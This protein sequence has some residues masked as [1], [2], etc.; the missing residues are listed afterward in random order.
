MQIGNSKYR[1]GRK[2][3]KERTPLIVKFVCDFLLLASL[4]IAVIWPDDVIA[5]KIGV[6][7]KLAS[8]F[9]SEH[10]P[11]AVQQD[12]ADNKDNANEQ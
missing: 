3:W 12:I 11:H 8:N 5:L 1:V 6:A 4:L 10:M 7:I 2:S 9:I